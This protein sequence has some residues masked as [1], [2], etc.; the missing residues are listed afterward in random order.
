MKEL[1]RKE[2][3]EFVTNIQLRY[4]KTFFHTEEPLSRANQAFKQIKQMVGEY[5]YLKNGDTEEEKVKIQTAPKKGKIPRST[6]RQVVKAVK[7]RK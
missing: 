4:P 1:N 7:V 2:L 6:I 3:L 5:P